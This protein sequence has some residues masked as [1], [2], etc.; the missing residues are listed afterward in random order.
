MGYI[1]FLASICTLIMI[2]VIIRLVKANR[3]PEYSTLR[4][5]L[6]EASSGVNFFDS[7]D[8]ENGGY[9]HGF[10]RYVS[11]S[12]RQARSADHCIS[13]A[14]ATEAHAL[15]LTHTSVNSA[16]LRIDTRDDL[17]NSQRAAARVESRAIYDHGLFVFDVK[18]A[19][20]ACATWSSLRIGDHIAPLSMV[21]SMS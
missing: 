9:A 2:P 19:P 5:T 14:N 1:L 16:N 8:Y 6:T 7:F 10:T 17:K 18:H 4:Y 21:K 12:P 3:Y 20:S 15:N 11:P 13:Y